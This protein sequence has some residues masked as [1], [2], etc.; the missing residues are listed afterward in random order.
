LAGTPED[1]IAKVREIEA[2]GI[3]EIWLR[4]FSAPRTEVEHEKVIVPFAE[5]VMPHFSD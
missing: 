2:S 1:C 3:H 4:C 5:T